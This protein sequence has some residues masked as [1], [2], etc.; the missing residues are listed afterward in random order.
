MRAATVSF[1]AIMLAFQPVTAQAP[2]STAQVSTAPVKRPAADFAKLP[3]L[4]NPK[5]S[6]DGTRVLAKLA[7]RGEAVLAI[8]P[9]DAAD[10][11]ILIGLGE[12]DLVS[13]QWV[14]K[15]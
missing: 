2:T 15:D 11:P 1:L 14:N 7:V 10:K 8:V 9:V 6:P 4:A 5:L 12:N 13:W 3:F